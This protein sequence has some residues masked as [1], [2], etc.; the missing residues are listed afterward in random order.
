MTSTVVGLRYDRKIHEDNRIGNRLTG[1]KLT[2]FLLTASSAGVYNTQ[3][4]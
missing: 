4:D 2:G 1:F 3:R